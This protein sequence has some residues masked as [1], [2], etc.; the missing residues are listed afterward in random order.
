[1]EIERCPT[2]I[3]GLDELID[4]GFPRGRVILLSGGCGTGKSILATQF[5]YNGIVKYDE[6]G[7]LVTLEQNPRLF[8]EDMSAMGFD[9]EKVEAEKKLAIIDASLSGMA[10]PEEEGEYK[11]SNRSSFNLD[12]LLGLISEASKDIGAK[13]AVV[14]S[15]SALDSL[16]ET[17]KTRG[18][19]HIEDARKTMLGI[20]Y[21]LQSMGLTS[22]LIS[23]M[24]KD[25]KFSKYG[26]EEFMVDGVITLHYNVVGPDAGRHLIIRKMRNT[27]HSENIST[28]EFA[29]G[30]G[31][32]VKGF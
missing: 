2:G 16:I 20:N 9:L 4:G 25:E 13:R 15:F 31:I 21:K 18:G 8:K 32:V 26:V 17:L 3:Q 19:S 24:L 29:K 14:D 11:I 5:L 6:P 1:M 12:S 22:I 28:I 7:I 23:D 30:E 10:F 27:E